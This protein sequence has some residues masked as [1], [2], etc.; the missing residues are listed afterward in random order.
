[1]IV[2][3]SVAFKWIASEADSDRAIS[4]IGAGPLRAPALLLVEVANAIWKQAQ[5]GEI[6]DAM[7]LGG[8]VADLARLV[9]IVDD[10]ELVARALELACELGH[11]AYDCLY[12]ALAERD[13]DILVT[14]DSR[15]LARLAGTAY[16][17]LVR[18]LSV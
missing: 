12:L 15:F 13:S 6:G 4:L 7:S 14:A 5:R 18:P 17:G 16:A 2:D 10:P 9:D 3:A 11:P 8:M 1:M